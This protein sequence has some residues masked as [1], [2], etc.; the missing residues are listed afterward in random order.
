MLTLTRHGLD[1]AWRRPRRFYGST[2][3][4]IGTHPNSVAIGDFNSDGKQDMAVAN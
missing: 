3:V 1:P 2:E 4:A